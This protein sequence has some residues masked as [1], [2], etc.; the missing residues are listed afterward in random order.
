MEIL[1][2]AWQLAAVSFIIWAAVQLFR[3][4]RE[5]NL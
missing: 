4:L 1:G 2:Y 5:G 3:L